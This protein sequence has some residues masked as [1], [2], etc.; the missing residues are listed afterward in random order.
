MAWVIDLGISILKILEG[1]MIFL[2]N[3]TQGFSWGNSMNGYVDG[4]IWYAEMP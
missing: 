1:D 2:C 3:L 4:S